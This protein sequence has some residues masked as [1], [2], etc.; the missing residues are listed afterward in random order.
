MKKLAIASAV[1]SATLAL[2]AFAQPYGPG[3]GAGA[4]KGPG[5]RF[6][7]TTTP[8]WSMMSAQERTEHQAKMRAFTSYDEC[9]AYMVEHHKLMEERAKGKGKALRGAGPGPGCDWLKKK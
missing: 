4:G 1:A 3:P 2:A 8:G 7:D 6:N 9:H 5:P